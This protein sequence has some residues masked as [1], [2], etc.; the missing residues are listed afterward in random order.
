MEAE[1]A[2]LCP[3]PGSAPAACVSPDPA[4]AASRSRAAAMPVGACAGP[5]PDPNPDLGGVRIPPP[6]HQLGAGSARDPP[7]PS[8]PGWCPRVGCKDGP[9]GVQA[10]FWELP[11]GQVLRRQ[12]QRLVVSPERCQRCPDLA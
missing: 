5:D 9:Q 6:V 4:A 8:L 2:E 1:R 10:S 12:K 11:Q 3:G 7:P